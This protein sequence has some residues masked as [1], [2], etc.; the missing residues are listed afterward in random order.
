MLV[1][2]SDMTHSHFHACVLAG[3]SGERFW[4]MSRTRRPK[5]LLKLISDRTLL[6]EAVRRLE[7]VVP[8]ANVLVLTSKAQLE[9]VRAALPF[10]APSQVV[11]E[12]ARRDTAPA[13]AL[14][15]AIVRA[16]DPRGIVALLPAD[17]FIRDRA[18]FA[19]QLA[20]GFEL[21]RG[22]DALLTFAV[23]PSHPST[24]FGYLELGEE[25]ARTK[26]GESLRKVK[27]FVEKP[28]LATARRYVE[29]GAFAWNAGM[30][31]WE[32]DAFLREAERQAPEIA[33]FIREFP[34]GQFADYVA[35]RFPSLP[36]LSVDYAIM[37]KAARVATVVAAFDW[38]DVGLWTALPKHLPADA[39][40]NA[41]RG[42]VAVVNSS[43]NIAVGTGR[44]IALCG[45]KD[46][47]V[48]ETPDA[49]L[50]CH[51]DAVQDI[52][53]LH[54]SLPKELL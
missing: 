47:V 7:G 3:G 43:N 32:A 52:K 24:G 2:G 27:R 20:A 48:V 49:V 54:P 5:H 17:S 21:A 23:K 22:K 4:P 35:E 19:E 45:V 53:K 9:D 37:E 41:T 13:A 36:K 51:R 42:P 40:G 18:R 33:A 38:D 34:K 30:F 6:E 11:A 39:H 28:D 12:P 26:S 14:A 8:Q 50:V 29:S 46:L 1:N 16:R 44:L 15:T 25:L 31:L 10:L